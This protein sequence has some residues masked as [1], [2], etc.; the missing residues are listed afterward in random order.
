MW[1]SQL[2]TIVTITPSPSVPTL[3]EI[4]QPS[5]C[6][7]HFFVNPWLLVLFL[8]TPSLARKVQFF[9]FYMYLYPHLVRGTP[10]SQSTTEPAA[11]VAVELPPL[12]L[13][14]CH[15]LF[16]F[17]FIQE[18]E[19]SSVPQKMMML[20]WR[21]GGGSWKFVCCCDVAFLKNEP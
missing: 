6:L 3:P 16:L 4:D 8:K 12:S 13:I 5:F 1:F 18:A 14:R 11:S 7:M 17:R 15:G 2:V 21:G 10:A 9:S 20:R 19:P